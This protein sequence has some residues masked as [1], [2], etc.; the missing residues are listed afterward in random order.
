M[1]FLYKHRAVLVFFT[2]EVRDDLI[3]VDF[4]VVMHIN[5]G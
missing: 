5:H 2:G 1:V 4:L 3:K